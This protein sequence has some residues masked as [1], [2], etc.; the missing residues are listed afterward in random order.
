MAYP[1]HTSRPIPHDLRWA[2]YVDRPSRRP[3]DRETQDAI[4]AIKLES[5]HGRAEPLFTD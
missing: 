5:R 4:A 1:H 2:L 3:L